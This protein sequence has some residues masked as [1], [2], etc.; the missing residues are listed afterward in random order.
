MDQ[1]KV[2]TFMETA[3]G[4][5]RRTVRAESIL[6]GGIRLT[7]RRR[8]GRESPVTKEGVGEF[9]IF[10]F[11]PRLRDTLTRGCGGRADGLHPPIERLSSSIG[12]SWM[13]RPT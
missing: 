8:I 9:V 6:F 11:A 10:D 2:K 3:R 13:M 1:A 4:W 12:A 5:D 7:N